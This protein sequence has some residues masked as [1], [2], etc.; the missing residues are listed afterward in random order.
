M[1]PRLRFV[2][3]HKINQRQENV[4]HAGIVSG[5]SQAAQAVVHFVSV[6][7]RQILRLRDAEQSQILRHGF[8]DIGQVGQC[9]QLASLYFV[10][11]HVFTLWFGGRL[12]TCNRMEQLVFA[13]KAHATFAAVIPACAGMTAKAFLI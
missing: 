1:P 10:G 6:L 4:D 7:P 3:L 5:C 2:P 8:A 9:I 13:G 11:V 12:K